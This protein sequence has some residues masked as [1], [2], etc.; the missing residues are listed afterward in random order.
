MNPVSIPKKQHAGT[1]SQRFQHVLKV[2][3][4]AFQVALMTVAILGPGQLVGWYF[5]RK[6]AAGETIWLDNLSFGRF[7]G[8]SSAA[9]TNEAADLAPNLSV[10]SRK[11]RI[12][13]HD[14]YPEPT[15]IFGY[16]NPPISGN[17]TAGLGESEYRRAKKM[18]HT[19]DYTTPWGGMEFFFHNSNTFGAMKRVLKATWDNRNLSGVVS[20]VQQPVE[21]PEM[22]TK[23]VKDIALE[24]GAVL[25]G[26]TEVKD[27]HIYE[28]KEVPYRLAISVAVTMDRENMLEVPYEPAVLAV[29]DAYVDVGQIAIHVAT[30]IRAMGWDAL[31]QTNLEGECSVLHLPIALDAGLGEL[32][33]HGS[34]ITQAYG[35]N[36][37]LAT[38]L[39]DLPMVPDEPVDIGVDDFCAKC[40][41][42]V[43]NCPPHAIFDTK[44]MVRGTERWY[45]NF[46][47]CVPYFSSHGGCGICI[48]V[49]PWS[50]AGRGPIMTEKMFAKRTGQK[51][52]SL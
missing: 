43:T 9:E 48:E 34:M 46:D 45:V 52:I 5:R 1:L 7:I 41:V 20:Q 29:M 28:G 10:K 25:V 2:T 22:M 33:K 13:K 31:A 40:Q 19:H 39:T 23:L 30:R 15:Y 32:G 8:K 50:E 3:L 12:I 37:R 42:C 24:A 38:I 51:S 47:T 6:A 26:I 11:S 49:C 36:V 44:Q 27:H 16:K 21:D 17:V 14:G 35:S 4:R 18:F